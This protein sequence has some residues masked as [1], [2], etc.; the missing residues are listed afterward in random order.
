MKDRKNW[1]D[2]PEHKQKMFEILGGLR[3]G[4]IDYP[5]SQWKK[6]CETCA[7]ILSK[8]VGENIRGSQIEGQTLIPTVADSNKMNKSTLESLAYGILGGFIFPE[9]FDKHF[10]KRK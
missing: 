1:K 3:D 4:K 5:A 8:M 7:K 6:D 2:N 9:D 10:Y